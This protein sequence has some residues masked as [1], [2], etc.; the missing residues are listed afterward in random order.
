VDNIEEK[1]DQQAEE[2]MPTAD[3]LVDRGKLFVYNGS[4]APAAP[5]FKIENKHE[6][7]GRVKKLGMRIL[8]IILGSGIYWLGYYGFFT[9]PESDLYS[10]GCLFLIIVGLI[11]A[12]WNSS[13][14]Y[15]GI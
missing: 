6:M 12:S 11:I 14:L 3:G 5:P 1:R 9:H 7:K 15:R 10:A 13:R 8:L 4:Q 2:L